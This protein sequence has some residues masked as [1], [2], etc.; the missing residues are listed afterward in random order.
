M[1]PCLLASLLLAV[2]ALASHASAR[3]L[4]MIRERGT[5]GL[6][7]HPNSL[8]FASRAGQPPGFQIEMA[9]ALAEQLG[10][11]LTTEWIISTIQIRRADCDIVLD[12]IAD[13]QAQEESGL[14]VS[15]PYYRTG[16]ALT[17]KPDSAI[18]SFRSLN[19][20]TK[21]GVQVGSTA[22]MV[23]GQRKVGI[24][25]FGLEDDALDALSN[26]EIDAATVTP[27]RA[28]YYNLMHP[29]KAV[30]VLGLDESEPDMSWNVG[31]G[32]MR[33]DERLR[34]AINEALDNLRSAGRIEAIYGRYGITLLSPQ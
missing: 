9:R 27:A 17:V 24:S 18:T 10:V 2:C 4:D 31:V 11:S 14:R 30:R 15:K 13:N 6:C 1:K 25:I 21:V 32:M 22:A 29:D 16:A 23:L 5:I 26:H 20:K 7:A 19:E 33:P 12:A 34:N 8:P 3:S 28:G